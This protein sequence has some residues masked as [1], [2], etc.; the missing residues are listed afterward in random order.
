M[1]RDGTPDDTDPGAECTIDVAY[2]TSCKAPGTCDG[3]GA[4]RVYAKNGIVSAANTCSG[5]TLTS[6]TCDGAGNQQILQT[7]CYP[8]KCNAGSTA[9]RVAC[10]RS[11]RNARCCASD[12]HWQR[13]ANRPS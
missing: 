5:S 1:R 12:T 11:S 13:P 3:T 4:C 8:Y 10:T 7:P 2:P 6:K 9:C